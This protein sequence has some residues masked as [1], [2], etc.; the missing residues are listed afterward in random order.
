MQTASKQK[1][2]K[3]Q[4]ELAELVESMVSG[5]RSISTVALIFMAIH[6]VLSAFLHRSA[7]EFLD[8]CDTLQELAKLVVQLHNG[9][10]RE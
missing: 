1:A 10:L 2:V 6:N 9:E 5:D 8:T 7:N 4:T 3:I